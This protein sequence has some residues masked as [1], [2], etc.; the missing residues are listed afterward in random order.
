MDV[1]LFTDYRFAARLEQLLIEW[2][3]DGTNKKTSSSK[4]FLDWL[5]VKTLW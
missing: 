3:L 2:K 1:N 4:V 5:L